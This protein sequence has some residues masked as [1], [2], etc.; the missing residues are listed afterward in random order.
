LNTPLRWYSNSNPIKFITKTIESANGVA[1]A[2][3]PAMVISFAKKLKT[4]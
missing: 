3:S 4:N 2:L 1:G